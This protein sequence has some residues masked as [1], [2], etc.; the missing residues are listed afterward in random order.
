MARP[1]RTTQEQF[2]DTFADWD[3]A[4]QDQMLTVLA[5]LHRWCRRERG[6]KREE[7]E[8]LPLTEDQD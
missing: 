5:K 3:L 1:K 7:A 8:A 4:T 6:G 2:E